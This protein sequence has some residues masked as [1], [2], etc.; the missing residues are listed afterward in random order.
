MVSF[1]TF[2]IYYKSRK[3]IAFIVAL[4]FV[5]VLS[6]Y[7]NYYVN[8]YVDLSE[9]NQNQVIFII[10]VT[11]VFAIGL[12]FRAYYFADANL[13]EAVRISHSVNRNIIMNEL[14]FY[15]S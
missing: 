14:S 13:D 12:F 9:Y 15:N 5:T 3:H 6:N 10:T 2:K 7:Y 8:T 4:I 1:S 11:L